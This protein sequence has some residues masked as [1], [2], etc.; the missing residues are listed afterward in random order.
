MNAVMERQKVFVM[1]KPDVGDIVMHRVNKGSMPAVA[2]VVEVFDRTVTLHVIAPHVY[3]LTPFA[4]VRHIDDPDVS[5]EHEGGFWDFRPKDVEI[6]QRLNNMEIAL[7]QVQGIKT[8]I[9]K[10][11]EAAEK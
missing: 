2:M 4:A 8:A 10:D 7:A 6:R 5:L 9:A 11:R 3:N 1:P